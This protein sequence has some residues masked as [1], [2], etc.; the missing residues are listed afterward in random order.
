M[1]I[2]DSPT[3]C[4]RFA[5]ER[6]YHRSHDDLAH[7]SWSPS[8]LFFGPITAKTRQKH[9]K[10]KNLSQSGFEKHIHDFWS[11]LSRSLQVWTYS[12]DH[13]MMSSIALPGSLLKG[14]GSLT[15]STRKARTT[16]RSRSYA[17]SVRCSILGSR[18]PSWTYWWKNKSLPL[19]VAIGS[20]GIANRS[21]STLVWRLTFGHEAEKMSHM[22]GYLGEWL[23][24]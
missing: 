23:K 11:P 21:S 12:K 16:N 24:I 4:H 7:S 5:S 9:S 17:I 18:K 1:C 19:C 13:L 15:W 22:C 10:A 20:R 14:C 3:G 2:R 8:C 6:S